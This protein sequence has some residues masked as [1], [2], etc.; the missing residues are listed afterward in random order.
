MG[1]LALILV[2]MLAV[3]VFGLAPMH[4][5][6]RNAS[7]QGISIWVTTN[8]VHSALLLPRRTSQ[9]DWAE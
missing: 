6:W 7:A 8:G 2:Y 5:P 1:V 4:R 9:I 3:L